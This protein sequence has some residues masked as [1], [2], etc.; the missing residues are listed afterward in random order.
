M[1]NPLAVLDAHHGILALGPGLG[2]AHDAAILELIARAPQPMILDADALN[3]LADHPAALAHCAGPRLLTPHPGEMAR[4]DPGASQRSRRDTVEIFTHEHPHTL[5]LKG[6]RTLVGQRGQP[7]SYNST[8][9]PG[10]ASGGIGDVL[11]GLLAALAAQ[12]HPLYDAARL[13]SWLIGRAAELA[14]YSGAESSET[15]RA[16]VILTHLASAF[17]DLRARCY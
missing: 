8:G 15:L 12:G 11:T 1:K 10:L 16:T 3:L 5:L 7:L 13:G 14:I 6:A 17:N 4:L 9:H 2:R